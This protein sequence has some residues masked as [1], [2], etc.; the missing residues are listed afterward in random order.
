MLSRC[1]GS[2]SL[3]RW[4]PHDRWALREMNADPQVMA[5][6]GPVMDAAAS[7]ALADRIDRHFSEHGFG[8]WCVVV[9]DEPVGWCGLMV[10]WFRDGVEIGWRLRSTQW[11]RGYATRAARLVLA[12]AFV[13]EPEGCGL[14]EVISFTAAVN[15]RSMAVMERLGME[16]DLGGD[17]LHPG[18]PSES[19]LAPHVLY[20]MS[21]ARYRDSL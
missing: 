8:L 19:R 16:R 18:V 3:R 1:D 14:D 11:G 9:D 5:T 4:T 20:R 7:D 21:A 15:H 13:P 2:L 10:P 6:I 12:E 17:F